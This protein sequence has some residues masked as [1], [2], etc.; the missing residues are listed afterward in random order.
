MAGRIG[1]HFGTPDYTSSHYFCRR[2][3][4]N[5]GLLV[6]PDELRFQYLWGNPLT[7]SNG[8]T[9]I[10]EQLQTYVDRTIGMVERD[11]DIVIVATQYRHRPLNPTE[12]TR[13]ELPKIKDLVDIEGEEIKKKLL[14][15]GLSGD[16]FAPFEWEDL[17]PFYKKTFVEFV[18][19][20]L[21]HRPI[22]E[23]QKWILR[24][25]VSDEVLI[26]LQDWIEPNYE[27][28]FVQAYPKQRQGGVNF[29][30]VVSGATGAAL[31]T[32][33]GVT[34]G[35]YPYSFE[36]FPRGYALDYI[37][38]YENARKV[39]DD[40]MEI[41][42]MLAAINLMADFGDGVVSGLANASVS[43]SG[44]SES[45]GTTLSATSAFFGARQKDYTERINKWFDENR[46]KYRGLKWRVF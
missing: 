33:S 44:I 1:R 5:W 18:Q 26:D 38:G 17:Y 11:L 41:I 9:F 6:T 35:L 22:V 20:K 12:K 40:L 13:E 24:N 43:L 46:I 27:R 3:V 37:A 32:A 10:N 14:A 45:F 23:F 7:S 39:P 34:A 19:L 29:P 25:P 16:D 8:E 2:G 15:N 28:G 36:R 30:V 42:G 21:K 4:P 31:A